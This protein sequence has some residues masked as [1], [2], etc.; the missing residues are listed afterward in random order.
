[1]KKSVTRFVASWPEYFYVLLKAPLLYTLAILLLFELSQHTVRTVAHYLI[2]DLNQTTQ[3]TIVDSRIDRV[4]KYGGSPVR[5]IEYTYMVEGQV[6]RSSMVDYTERGYNPEAYLRKY[7]K[8]DKVVVLYDSRF[9]YLSL[10]YKSDFNLGLIVSLGVAGALF[11]TVV[12]WRL[13]V[14]GPKFISN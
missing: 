2:T 4:G 14:S 8:G 3:G 6:Y 1:M 9:P 10:L 11:A 7:T 12:A 13:W 5:S